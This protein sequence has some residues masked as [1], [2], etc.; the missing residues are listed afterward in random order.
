MCKITYGQVPVFLVLAS[1]AVR[2]S[3]ADDSELSRA[4]Q[5]SGVFP[6]E[7]NGDEP[8]LNNDRSPDLCSALT[9]DQGLCF[10]GAVGV[11][12]FSLK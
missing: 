5:E 8:S 4:S 6:V 9:I 7:V 10:C 3:T 12:D 1:L 11:A 2:L